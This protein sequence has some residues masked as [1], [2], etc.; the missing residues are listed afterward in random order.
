MVRSA[1]LAEAPEVRRR[2]QPRA[3]MPIE[4]LARRTGMTVRN[5]RAMQARSLLE[6]PDLEGR[7]GFYTERHEARVLLVL[8][9]QSRGFSL[10]AIHALIKGWQ[11]GSG[12]MDVMGLEDAL[13]TPATGAPAEV[14]VADA[15]PELLESSR[16]LA[17]AI[18]QDLVVW[19]DDRYVAPN[20]ELLGIVKQQAAAGFPLEALLN[21][22][23]AL[24]R[25]VE[26]IATRFRKSFF[27]HIVNPHLA[28]GA[29]GAALPD[30]AAKIALL[31]PI[32][33]RLVSILLARAIERGG[34][35]IADGAEPTG[36]KALG[37]KKTK[38]GK[39]RKR[40]KR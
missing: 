40:G 4:E 34:S 5:L 16:A 31:R 37:R 35:P 3:R 25:D 27:D 23:D 1:R 18:E 29:P 12:I 21:D 13:L 33:V 14:D 19:K 39:T 38:A 6:P 10:A 26:R 7:K 22:G 36:S 20:A 11:E 2:D 30:L 9:L 15:F 32:S 17:K 24:L 28:A 8:K